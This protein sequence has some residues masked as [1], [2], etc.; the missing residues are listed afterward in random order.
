MDN[1]P[2]EL[3]FEI[4]QN[5]DDF[6]TL[7]NLKLTNKKL[8]GIVSHDIIPLKKK[9]I[10]KFIKENPNADRADVIM[11]YL[12]KGD[13]ISCRIL[14]EHW[15]WT[16]TSYV[17][18]NIYKDFFVRY[19]ENGDYEGHQIRKRV[20]LSDIAPAL[21]AEQNNFQ[22]FKYYLRKASQ[23]KGS[24]IYSPGYS[25]YVFR[26]IT[27]VKSAMASFEFIEQML[28]FKDYEDDMMGSHYLKYIIFATSFVSGD[29]DTFIKFW[30]YLKNDY[31][32][33]EGTADRLYGFMWQMF[34]Y[35][36]NEWD[37]IYADI[38]NDSPSKIIENWYNENKPFNMAN[39]RFADYPVSLNY[40]K[41]VRICEKLKKKY[42]SINYE[43]EVPVMQ[44]GFPVYKHFILN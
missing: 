24:F 42:P 8:H 27:T 16:G 14:D 30:E 43:I 15:N 20:Y 9:R 31:I 4:V 3:L 25:N 23:T 19:Y 5:I 10:L 13:N 35:I 32:K 40:Q 39:P 44:Y 11:S 34:R 36:L 29:G 2:D 33:M 1:L 28:Q 38:Y 21:L 6:E 26:I 41:S 17:V 37:S 12:L 22:L 7:D 18:D